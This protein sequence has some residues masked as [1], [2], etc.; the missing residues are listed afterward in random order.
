QFDNILERKDAIKAFTENKAPINE[1]LDEIGLEDLVVKMIK[2]AY[3]KVKPEQP[4]Y[5][6]ILTQG[7]VTIYSKSFLETSIRKE[8]IGGLLTAIYTMSEDVF[9]AGNSVQRIKHNDY[10]VIIK[11]IEELLFS[12][13][14]TGS[15]YNALEKLENLISVLSESNLIWSALIRELPQISVAEKNGLDI[16]VVDLI[17]NSS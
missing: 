4:A 9:V 13:V 7:G 11:P 2:P 15:S 17:A 16:I 12:Y 10:T 6:F 1:R 14:F 3:L 8:L 5:F